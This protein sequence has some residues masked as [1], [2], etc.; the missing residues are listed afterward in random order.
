M[1]LSWTVSAHL[2]Y[3]CGCSFSCSRLLAVVRSGSTGPLS[4]RLGLLGMC[5]FIL[6]VLGYSRMNIICKCGSR[7]MCS[8]VPVSLSLLF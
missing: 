8:R 6:A 7:I 1:V 4:L 2:L 5:K 3:S